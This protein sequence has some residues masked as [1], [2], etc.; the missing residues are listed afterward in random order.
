M[1][2]TVKRLSGPAQLT[3]A[4]ATLITAGATEKVEIRHIHVYN[5]GASVNL[6]MSITA[7]AASKRIFDAYPIPTGPYDHF[8]QYVLD[9]TEILQAF[10]SVASQLVVT[11]NGISHT[12]G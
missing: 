9:P 4:A 10:A 2:R 12:L 6:T 5:P 1:A 3:A 7:D 11:I 8:G